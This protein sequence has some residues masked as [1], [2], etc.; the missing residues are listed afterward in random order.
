MLVEVNQNAISGK[1]CPD[2]QKSNT[3]ICKF[4]CTVLLISA[5]CG[6]FCSL[7]PLRKAC[8]YFAG[9]SREMACSAIDELL[10]FLDI[11]P[12]STILQVCMHQYWPLTFQGRQYLPFCQLLLSCT[13][14]IL[15]DVSTFYLHSFWTL[16]TSSVSLGLLKLTL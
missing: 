10:C 6:Q 14:F 13:S 3:Q 12:T 2:Y 9:V 4:F 15:G 8:V 1:L 7:S 16:P 5:Y 11:F